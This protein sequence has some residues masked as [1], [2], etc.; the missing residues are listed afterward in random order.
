MKTALIIIDM[1]NGFMNEN[2]K[3]LVPKIV[4]FVKEQSFDLVIGTRYINS[5]YTACHIYEGWDGCW[6]GNESAELVPE[7]KGLCDEVVDKHEYSCWGSPI[8]YL[9]GKYGIEKLVFCGVNT[10]CCVLASVFDAYDE[11]WDITVVKDLCGSTSGDSSHKAGI[12]I[13]RECITESRV[14][15]TQSCRSPKYNVGDEVICTVSRRGSYEPSICSS[16]S[17][18]IINTIQSTSEGYIYVCDIDG[19]CFK[20]SELISEKDF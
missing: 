15:T 7:I 12:Q 3:H 2:T 16:Y 4:D 18:H 10:G 8:K 11:L 5:N 1:Q 6:E 20:E 14:T 17:R 19:Y 13:L 9:L